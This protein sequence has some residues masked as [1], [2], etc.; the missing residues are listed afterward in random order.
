[1]DIK[2]HFTRYVMPV[3]LNMSLNTLPPDLVWMD[4]VIVPKGL[5]NMVQS[6]TNFI[7]DIVLCCW[8]EPGSMDGNRRHI[9]PLIFS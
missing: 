3:N 7:H 5:R 1:V 9:V 6:L 8:A 4:S 2:P